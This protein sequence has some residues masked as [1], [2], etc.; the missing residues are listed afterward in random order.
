MANSELTLTNFTRD[1]AEVIG[2]P[3][4]HFRVTKAFASSGSVRD[5]SKLSC[6]IVAI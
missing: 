2:D 5:N 4:K 6:D 1:P 3:G